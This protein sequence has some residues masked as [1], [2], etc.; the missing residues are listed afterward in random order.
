MRAARIRILIA[1]ELSEQARSY[2][3]LVILALFG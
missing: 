1:K 2:R 3:L